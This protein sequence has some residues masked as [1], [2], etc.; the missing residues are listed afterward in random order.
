[1]KTKEIQVPEIVGEMPTGFELICSV[2]FLFC[3]FA[4]VV[5]LLAF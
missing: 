5:M 4:C 1:M 2:L 3:L